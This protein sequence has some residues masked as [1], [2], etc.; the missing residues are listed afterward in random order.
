M[1][2]EEKQLLDNRLT[3]I[4]KR[5][6]WIADEEARSAWVNGDAARGAYV[7]E[8]LA[9]LDETDRILDRLEGKDT[10]A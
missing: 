4:H 2:E 1:T 9:L 6:Q 7:K 8:K 10:D 5:V 3:S